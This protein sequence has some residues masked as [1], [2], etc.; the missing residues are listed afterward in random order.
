MGTVGG[1]LVPRLGIE[2]VSPAVEAQRP[3]HWTTREDPCSIFNDKFGNLALSMFH[4]EYGCTQRFRVVPAITGL[5]NSASKMILVPST[6]LN[7]LPC[8]PYAVIFSLI[9]QPFINAPVRMIENI[10]L[11]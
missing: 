11:M 8:L 6:C 1:I 4:I 9:V 10:S 2:P 7:W 3:N 5:E